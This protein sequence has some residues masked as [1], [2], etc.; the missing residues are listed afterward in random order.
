MYSHFGQY[1]GQVYRARFRCTGYEA[2]L[3]SCRHPQ[4]HRGTCDHR[5]TAGVR[6]STEV[7]SNCTY[8]EVRLVNGEVPYEGR[9]EVC[10][11]NTWGTVCHDSWNYL[12][13]TVV[14]HQLGYS[15]PNTRLVNSSCIAIRRELLS[16]I[17]C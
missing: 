11:S 12:D 3:H 14:C 2:S 6:C 13:A 9:V 15:G 17:F 1:T 4:Y 8:G 16:Y 7:V 5:H 10:H